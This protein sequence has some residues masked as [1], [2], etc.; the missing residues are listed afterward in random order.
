MTAPLIARN[1]AT[2]APLAEIAATEPSAVAALVDRARRV[3]PSWAALSW[4]ERRSALAR[5]HRELARRADELAEA[6]RL[7]IGKPAGEAMAAEVVPSLDALLWT[8][9][10]AGRVLATRRVGRAGSGSC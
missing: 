3:Q 7:E 5:W 8:V 1:P 9:R 10:T 2:G 4:R 6:V